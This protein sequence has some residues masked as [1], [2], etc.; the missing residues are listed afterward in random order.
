MNR[1]NEVRGLAW[2]RAAI[3]NAEWTG[4]KLTDLLAAHG[5]D[6][7]DARI[8]HVQFEGLDLDPGSS[9]YGASI[10]V[11]KVMNERMH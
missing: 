1:V 8:K 7:N 9:P 3:S 5:A 2:Q 4:V 10:P 6:L 11:E